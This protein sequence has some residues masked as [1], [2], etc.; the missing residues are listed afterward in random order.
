MNKTASHMETA[1]LKMH[2]A[3]NDF[4]VLD[5]RGRDLALNPGAV[6]ALAERRKGIGC[7]QVLILERSS[8][9]D[10]RMRIYNADGSEAGQCGNGTRCVAR[11][12]MKET[13]S[14]RV[15]IESAS[16]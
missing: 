4:I 9:A 8:K 14:K 15:V 12:V 13:Q 2:G 1:F 16:G 3:G 11:L 10:V 7:D 5:A 6:R